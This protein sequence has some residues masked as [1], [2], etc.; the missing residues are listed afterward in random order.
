MSGV[1]VCVIATQSELHKYGCPHTH[2]VKVAEVYYRQGV[3]P[4]KFNTP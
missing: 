3:E 2:K 1:R 4:N